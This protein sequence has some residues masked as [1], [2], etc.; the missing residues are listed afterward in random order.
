[1]VRPGPRKSGFLPNLSPPGVL[2]Q[3]GRVAPFRNRDNEA[4]KLLGAESWNLAHGL[5]KRGRKAGLAGGDQNFG[6]STFFIKGTPLK[7][8]VGGFLLMHIFDPTHPEGPMGPPGSQGVENQKSKLG[9]FIEG[10]PPPYQ[11]NWTF[12]FIQL[13]DSRQ[14]RGPTGPTK[15]S[16][17]GPRSL[18]KS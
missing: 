1:M 12:C 13:F 5:R 16:K 17:S 14:P 18:N 8:G 2:G 15:S 11:I 3:G 4:N 7:L 6:N 9:Y 10:P